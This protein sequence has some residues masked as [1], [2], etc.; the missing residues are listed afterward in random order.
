MGKFPT[1]S[2]KLWKLIKEATE[3]WH[4]SFFFPFLKKINLFIL[5]GG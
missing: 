4:I 2:L 3:N 5:I 1:A